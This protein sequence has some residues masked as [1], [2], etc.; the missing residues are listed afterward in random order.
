MGLFDSDSEEP[1]SK[2]RRYIVTGVALA[3]LLSWG[4]WYLFRFHAEKK[5]VETF[6]NAVARGDLQEAYR[7]WQ[8]RPSYAFQDFVEDWGPTGYYGPVKTYQIETAQ[9]ESGASGVVVV[10]ELSPFAPFPAA[11]ESERLR[12]MKGARLWVEVKTQAISFA[13]APLN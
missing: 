1:K 10:V 6:L 5:T 2:I 12:Q 9:R 13:P 3:L 4:A 11:N 8:P 7:L